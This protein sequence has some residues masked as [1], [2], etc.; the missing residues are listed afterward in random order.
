M[1]DAP[2]SPP[3]RWFALLI[4]LAAV[5]P[6]SS[7][8]SGCSGVRSAEPCAAAARPADSRQQPD[9]TIRVVLGLDVVRACPNMPRSGPKWAKVGSESGAGHAMGTRKHSRV[10]SRPTY[11]Q[12]D[13]EVV[14]CSPASS[15]TRSMARDELPCLPA[16][17]PSLRPGAHVT[18]WIDSCLAIFPNQAWERLADRVGELRYAD[19]GARAF[20]RFLFSGAFDVELDGQGRVVLPAGLRDFVGLKSEVVVVGALDHI[21]LW[22]PDRWASA[23]RGDE[24]RCV[25]RAH[26]Q[27]RDLAQPNEPPGSVGTVDNGIA[28]GG[29][30][31]ARDG[32]RS[33]GLAFTRSGQLPD[34]CNRWRRR[35]LP[36]N[37][38]GQFA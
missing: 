14:L 3:P 28:I 27:P 24:L 5:W 34:R 31:P 2:R 35:A 6:A 11:E 19:A 37:P 20:S 22:E 21:E 36:T 25:R 15:G 9:S 29:R 13:P 32:G 12:A 1:F 26:R 7:S 17:A 8:G 30:A 16:F 18:R 23:S 33:I 10:V 4:V 38:G